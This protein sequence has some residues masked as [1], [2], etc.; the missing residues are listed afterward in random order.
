[1]PK[2]ISKR[3]REA[4]RG[5]VEKGYSANRIQVKLRERHIGLRRKNLLSEVRKVRRLKPK[6]E[7]AKYIPKKYGQAKWRARAKASPRKRL[8]PTGERQVTI[9]GRHNGKEVVKTK[10]GS[11]KDLYH[12]VLD[13]VTGDYWDEK[14]YVTSR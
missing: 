11:G 8:R 7:V 14:P 12:F 1:L 4:I 10:R 2:H 3:Q 13:E 5:Y 6:T 9:I